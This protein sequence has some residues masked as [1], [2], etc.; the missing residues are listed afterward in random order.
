MTILKSDTETRKK[1]CKGKSVSQLVEILRESIASNELPPGYKLREIEFAGQYHVSRQTIR[2]AF[3]V[4]EVKGL[5]TRIQNRGAFVSRY[6]YQDLIDIYDVREALT[7][8]AYQ[9][10]ARR[11]PDGAWEEMI[12]LF[13]E[14]MERSIAAKDVRTFSN[15]ISAL[16]N[17]VSH[18]ANNKFI[19]PM[20]EQITDLTQVLTRRILLL[21]DRLEI[22]LDMN[23]RMLVALTNRD[24]E[25]VRLIF[26][27]MIS[28]SRD[29]ITKHREFL[30]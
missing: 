13:G 11:A 5:I 27:E 3:T 19:D 8:K 7:T 24:E 29:Y 28:V 10:A 20:L 9:L 14:D 22:G 18:Y 15:A 12:A 1:A 25:T 26:S 16:D 17:L 23:R 30:F 21:P 4:L 6:E 2:D